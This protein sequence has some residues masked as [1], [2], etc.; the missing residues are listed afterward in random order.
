MFLKKN[1]KARLYSLSSFKNL[2]KDIIGYGLMHGISKSINLLLLPFLTRQFTTSEYGTIDIIVTLSS[3]LALF[4]TVSLENTVMRFWNESKKVNK[5]SE[6]FSGTLLLVFSL[7]IIVCSIVYIFSEFLSDLLLQDSTYW[8][9]I[10]LGA[11]SALFM[12]GNSVPLATLRMRRRIIAYNVINIIQSIS[13]VGLAILLIIGYKFSVE[14]V[15]LAFVF[16]HFISFIIGINFN[17]AFVTTNITWAYLKP[18]LKY[19][20]PMF[21]AVFVTW[22]NNQADRFLLLYLL[23]LGAVGVFG[24]S[25][26]IAAII[27]MLVTIFRRAWSPL[28][29]D[30]IEDDEQS[31]NE[32]YKKTLNYYLV[33]MLSIG[34]VITLLSQQILN[35]LVPQEYHYGYVIIP[36]LIGAKILH[37]AASM[38]NLGTVISKKTIGNSIAAWSGAIVNVC[39]GLILIPIYGISGAAIGS[40]VAELIFM[41]IL[42]YISLKLT[43]VRYNTSLI[44]LMIIIYVI[45]S[46]IIVHL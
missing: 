3:L 35:L 6:L 15:F 22:L 39:L 11:L 30:A 10:F 27:A 28:A 26:K 21:P 36:W 32:F 40:F 4:I 33:T 9:Y 37:G 19:S 20:L 5:Q 31:R 18:S 1:L 46:I 45:L 24:A 12:A 43:S 34:L 44:L 17:S 25:A 42:W 38:T 23:G 7:G 14:G 13:Y 29:I 2:G 16:S 8:E 41:S